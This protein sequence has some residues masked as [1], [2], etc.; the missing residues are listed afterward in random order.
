MGEVAVADQVKRSTPPKASGDTKPSKKP[1]PKGAHA[2]DDGYI[3]FALRFKAWWEGIEAASLMPGDPGAEDAASKITVD[4]EPEEEEGGRW[5]EPR[6]AFCTR[7]W[8]IGEEDEVVHPGGADYTVALAKPM[9]LDSSKS[10]F[11]LSAGLGGG[12]RKLAA[13]LDLWVKGFELDADLAEHAM[14]LSKKHGH[15]RRAPVEPLIEDA[16]SLGEGKADGIL[17]RERLYR[18]RNK[19]K[20]LDDLFAAL[21][22]RGHIVLTDFVLCDEAAATDPIISAFLAQEAKASPARQEPALWTMADHKKRLLEKSLDLRIY[23]DESEKFST[24]IRAG[25]GQFVG[26]LSKADL[27]RRF[28]DEMMRVAEFWLILCK[29][30]ESGKFVYVRAHGIRGGE[31]V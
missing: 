12:T 27:S 14:A 28:V 25:W 6:R 20:F 16:L 19:A 24:M 31:S 30:L 22:P 1:A 29:A 17:M 11:D 13:T 3:P 10:T 5:P 2:A 15:D 18:V 4:P 26:G 9:A 21:K 23:E 7:L 8:G